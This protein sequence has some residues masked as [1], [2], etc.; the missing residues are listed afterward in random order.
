MSTLRCKKLGVVIGDTRVCEDLNLELGDGQSWA[1]LGRN[2]SGKTTLLHTLAGLRPAQQGSILLNGQSLAEQSKKQIARH[3]GVLFQ[4]EI[5]HFPTTVLEYTLMGRH[6]HLGWLQW[7]SEADIA[8]AEQALQQVD[9][10][11][12]KQRDISTL[13]GG[14]RRRMNIACLLTQAPDIALLDEP[15]NHLDLQHQIETLSLVREQYR[16]RLLLMSA[17]D[18]NLATR[19]CSHAILLFGDGKL[20]HGTFNDV[21]T[22]ASLQ[23]LYGVAI[24][25][26]QADGHT[27]YYPA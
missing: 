20:T 7:E 18:I 15:S 21:V 12:L 10:L 26:V 17:H 25:S 22:T 23:H 2:G 1:V 4:T 16:Q 24:N 13:S 11:D 3:L 9:L 5:D 8:I 19:F 6:P 14:E 27:L